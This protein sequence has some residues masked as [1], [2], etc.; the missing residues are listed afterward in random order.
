M[1]LIPRLK[2]GSLVL[3]S[4]VSD[5]VET[6]RCIITDKSRSWL[7]PQ[8]RQD[9]PI[10]LAVRFLL[11]HRFVCHGLLGLDNTA[12]RC[13]LSDNWFSAD[14]GGD[15]EPSA[16]RA[17]REAPS[18][19]QH[20]RLMLN[21]FIL[22]RSGLTQPGAKHGAGFR[23]GHP[24]SLSHFVRPIL[25]SR[26]RDLTSPCRLHKKTHHIPHIWKAGRRKKK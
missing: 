2:I 25:F 14:R 22:A 20:V 13:D 5:I 4:W 17:I 1:P 24:D 9:H 10:N 23:N 19:S 7:I 26:R 15:G 3:R 21:R 11:T 12:A 6:L 8:G 16:F 18:R